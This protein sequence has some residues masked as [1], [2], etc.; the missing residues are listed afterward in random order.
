MP[1]L[2]RPLLLLILCTGF[3][4]AEENLPELDVQIQDIS[5]NKTLPSELRN[6]YNWWQSKIKL[7]AAYLMGAR[8]AGVNVAVVDTGIDLNHVEFRGR[9]LAGY[10][11]FAPT[12]TAMDDHGHGTH[13]AGIIGA[14][15]DGSMVVGGAP[16]VKLIPI[17]VL[18]AAGSGS[19]ASFNAGMNFAAKS[20]AKVLNLSLGA[21]GPF[22]ASGIQQVVNA[23]KLV[24][25]AAGNSGLA[26]PEWPA[27][28][29]KEAW[30]KGQMIVVGA[31]DSNNKIASFS[32]R[33]GDTR[34]F[35]VVAPGVNI[36]STYTA[37]RY[38]YMSGTSMA[39]PVVTGLAAD[40]Y[41]RWMYLSANQ[42]ASIIFKTADKLG[43]S[44]AGTPDVV[45]GWGLV[46][47][48]RALQ[49]VGAPKV[50][51][52]NAGYYALAP[53]A[54]STNKLV[55][56]KAFGGVALTAT[57]D[58]GRAYSYDM[59]SLT[60]QRNSG[61]LN[62]MFSQMDRQLGML[63]Q[64]TPNTRLQ[65][66]LTEREGNTVVGSY[67]L[68][69]KLDDRTTIATGNQGMIEHFMGIGA[70]L[71]ELPLTTRFSNPYFNLNEQA[72]SYMGLGYQFNANQQIRFA[73][74]NSTD[75]AADPNQPL[76]NQLQQN[77][78]AAEFSQK[79]GAGEI[80]LGVGQLI[81]QGSLLGASGTQT[82]A[83]DFDRS[84]T[85]Y[86]TVTGLLPLSVKSQLMA[87][88]NLGN[89]RSAGQGLVGD[90]QTTTAGW[91]LGWYQQALLHEH[92]ALGFAVSQPLRVLSGQMNL[93][94][95]IVDMET[96]AISH[97]RYA[98]DLQSPATETDLELGYSRKMDKYTRVRFNAVYRH[99]A[100]NQDGDRTEVGLR[101]N[102]RF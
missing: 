14:A 48:E 24:V 81:E 66:S 11:A 10:N 35:Y 77:G 53:L 67:N 4:H 39:A 25:V 47:A 94:L 60:S 80:K 84:S 2:R 98:V 9:L 15:A 86:T 70:E 7:N 61:G 45:Y 87:Q 36:A 46:N 41:S 54:L 85:L 73:L 100:D 72:L 30:A 62:E 43:T 50:A 65:Y 40:I 79:L 64:R 13:V 31:V 58:F 19:E 76:R 82:G 56:S 18:N 74:L 52:Y 78:W 99:N 83:L 55:Q 68:I 95:P 33:A 57:D 38:A 16:D 71:G 23:G 37:N 96:G 17:K 63:E 6:S 51:V 42:V 29:A 102:H 12:R 59:G 5:S 93:Q 28:Y 1:V 20:S 21:P 27:R 34:Y 26:N 3:A 101:L 8:G 92:D 69:H 44:A 88:F 22:G 75:L 97:Q 90:S 91:S 32:N 89:T 49:P